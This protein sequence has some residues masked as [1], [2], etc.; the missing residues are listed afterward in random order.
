MK[1]LFSIDW[2]EKYSTYISNLDFDN[3]VLKIEFLELIK[4][5][6]LRQRVEYW[7][8]IEENLS[9]D[10]EAADKNAANKE[11]AKL[12]NPYYIG[13][14]NPNSDVLFIGKEKAFDPIKRPDLFFKESIDN[15]YQWNSIINEQEPINHKHILNKFKFNPMLPLMYD[16]GKIGK[17]K[18]WGMYAQVIS[19]LFCLKLDDVL[20]N[21]ESSFYQHC[22]STEIN[23]IPSKYS[24]NKEMSIERMSLIQSDFFKRFS[25]VI[26]GAKSVIKPEEISE[27]FNLK[28]NWTEIELGEIGNKRKRTLKA[29]KWKN[30][31]RTIIICDQLSGS[32]GWSE[33]TLNELVLNLKD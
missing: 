28:G 3:K 4:S 30:N 18:T 32:A 13:F 10:K 6:D 20:K 1:N 11:A 2:Q 33:K 29:Y 15:V 12:S 5:H 8:K 23:H 22:F 25:K 16:Y 31:S 24:E 9:N 7:K 21:D 26:I 27:L 19:K 14:G 17:R